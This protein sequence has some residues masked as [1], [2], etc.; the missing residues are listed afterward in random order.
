MGVAVALALVS[1]IV[2]G[3][4]DYAGGRI[5][6]RFAPVA[7]TLV[8]E[9]SLLMVLLVLVPLVEGDAPTERAM[10]WGMFGGFAGSLALIGLYATL[11]RGNMTVVAPVTGVV[12]ALVPVAVGFA[13]GERPD[14]IA[15]IGIAAAIVAVALI[16]GLLGVAGKQVATR[17]VWMAI[18]VGCGFGAMFVAYARAG[19]DAG[20]WPL[21]F[22]RFTGLPLVAAAFVW[23]QRRSG[24]VEMGRRLFI[25]ATLVGLLVCVANG[26]YLVAARHGLL[27]VVAAVGAMYPASTIVLASTLDGERASRSQVVGM[28]VAAGAVV[29][30]T[31]GS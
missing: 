31:I 20:L 5:S 24:P 1:A 6:R 10:L 17:T 16:G 8:A 2:Y 30:I 12:S 27:S 13:I 3:I 28:V 14:A 21:L 7:V 22:S 25:S 29:A 15:V 26:A 19:D 9:I 4:S 18:A 11:S 23:R